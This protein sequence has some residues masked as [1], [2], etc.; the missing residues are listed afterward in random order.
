MPGIGRTRERAFH[1]RTEDYPVYNL[2][3][4]GETM[5]HVEVVS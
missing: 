1:V 5:V 4:D 3:E 2:E